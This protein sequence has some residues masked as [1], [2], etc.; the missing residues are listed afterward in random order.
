MTQRSSGQDGQDGQDGRE[1]AMTPGSFGQPS[2]ISQLARSLEVN[3][4]DRRRA[5]TEEAVA[6]ECS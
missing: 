6:C 3:D 1:P 2:V 5:G 4:Q